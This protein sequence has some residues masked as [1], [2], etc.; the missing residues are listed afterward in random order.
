MAGCSS[1][2]F[3]SSSFQNRS[4]RTRP[5]AP[6][7]WRGP[8]PM[9]WE[10]P[11]WMG[12]LISTDRKCPLGAR[13]ALTQFGIKQLFSSPSSGNASQPRPKRGGSPAE[14]NW[15]PGLRDALLPQQKR[16]SLLLLLLPR[17]ECL[18]SRCGMPQSAAPASWADWPVQL[19]LQGGDC[20]RLASPPPTPPQTASEL[21]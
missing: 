7:A 1:P 16:Q 10:D 5:L 12:F 17:P 21:I 3:C 20:I 19:P 6:Q 8:L 18:P 11:S 2:Y 13:R 4:Q 9:L 14:A 15:G